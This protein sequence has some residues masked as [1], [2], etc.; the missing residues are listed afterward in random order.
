MSNVIIK[1]EEDDPFM[2]PMRD[3]QTTSEHSAGAF[4]VTVLSLQ[5]AA[6]TI[7]CAFGIPALCCAQ[8]P[9][10]S[11]L[12]LPIASRV[13]RVS[14]CH[15]S[16]HIRVIGFF[17]DRAMALP[18]FGASIHP[19]LIPMIAGAHLSVCFLFPPPLFL[20]YVILDCS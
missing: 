16:L 20:Y 14:S 15:S 18:E 2:C 11:P 13:I 9:A 3:P 8:A 17:L 1:M 12:Y 19:N 5:L 6:A 4:L 10:R 7:A